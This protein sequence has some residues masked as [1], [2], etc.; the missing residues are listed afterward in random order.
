M[1]NAADMKWFKENFHAEVEA[2]IA[3]TPFTLDLMVALACQETGDVWPIL[4]KKPLTVDQILALCVGDTIDFNPATNKGRKAFPRNKAALLAVPRGDAMFAIA[5]Q[6]LVDV[7][8]QIPSAFPGASN[9]NKFCRG[10]GMFQLDLQFFKDDPDYFLEKRY[11]KFSETLGKSIGELTVKAKKIHLFD[12]PS[13]TDMELTAVAIAY[14]TGSFKP[15]LGLKQGHFNGSKFYG[16]EIFDFLRVAHTV[17]VPGGTPVLPPP[18]PDNAIV[19]P[20]TPV[21][22]A[23][24][25]LV[26]HTRI[27]PLRV[28]S[29][30]KI[31]SP[32]TANVIAQLPDGHPVRAVTGTKVKNFLEIETSLLGA[33][34]R[35]F[36][37]ADFLAP[38]P[39][40]NVIPLV[41]PAAPAAVAVLAMAAAAPAPATGIVEVFMPRPPGLVTKRTAVAGAHSL[42]EPNMPKRAGATAD[43]LRASLGEVIDYLATDKPAHKR[44]KPRD[45]LTFCNIYAHDYCFLA[46][47]YLPR[48]WWTPGAIERLAHGESVEPLIENTIMEMRANDLFRWLRDFGPRFGWRQTGTPTKLQQEANQGAVGLIV[49]RRKQDGK[50]GHIVAVVAE[51]ETERAVRNAAGEVT[52]PLQSQ[53]GAANFR[54]G[55]GSLNWW[56]GDQFAESAFWL[57]P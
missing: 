1:P 41:Q 55:T 40:V 27:G 43:E 49:A 45:G 52:R 53:A 44:Y 18:A 57:H 20:P 56:K 35:G 23:G 54:R 17:P 47:V 36:A 9:P 15:A 4:R 3:G 30:A 51:T 26:V 8:Q 37:S 2:A 25:F 46:G 50:S 21:E 6:A 38:A 33:H 12:K 5:R 14:N 32:P 11:E 19:P 42:N 28:R 48:V 10:Y 39:G 31:S 16:E 22:A 29:D 7:A 34:I 24:P 13:L